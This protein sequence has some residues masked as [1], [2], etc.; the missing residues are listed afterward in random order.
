MKR[1]SPKASI[2]KR[3][4]HSA[5]EEILTYFDERSEKFRTALYSAQTYFAIEGI[6]DLRVEMKR[7]RILYELIDHTA[8]SFASKPSF[9]PLKNLFQ[10]AGALR[11]I[12]I[13]QAIALQQLKTL[14]LC[15]YVNFLKAEEL[16]LRGAFRDI[17]AVFPDTTLTRS[18]RQIHSFLAITQRQRLRKCIENRICELAGAVQ[19][20]LAF[21]K[22]NSIRL[23]SS[24]KTSKALRYMLDIR[25]ACY[26]KSESAADAINQLKSTY[27]CLGEWR[28]NLIA[29]RSVDSFLESELQIGPADSLAYA[30]FRAGLRER[31][32]QLMVVYKQCRKPLRKSLKRLIHA[33]R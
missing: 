32:E 13:F 19:D 16:R 2:C 17:S 3:R 25:Q 5:A 26:G 27:D 18:R 24:R 1:P 12:D 22:Q 31:E 15:E 29:R 6:H 30:S 7:L 28:D 14:D 4:S 8:P 21:K 10:A 20:L 11:D 9:L 33:L 23:H